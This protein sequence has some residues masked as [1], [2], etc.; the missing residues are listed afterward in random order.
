VLFCLVEDKE[1]KKIGVLPIPV[2]AVSGVD[3]TRRHEKLVVV[4]SEFE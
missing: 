4:T 1:N 3:R 2:F